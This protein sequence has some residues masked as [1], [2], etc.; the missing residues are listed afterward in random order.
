MNSTRRFLAILVCTVI[1]VKGNAMTY[2]VRKGDTLGEVLYRK[3]P[4]RIYGSGNNLEKTKRLN[5]KLK[6]I[7]KLTPGFVLKLPK[8][9]GKYTQLE[10]SNQSK[11]NEV[12]NSQDAIAESLNMQ[13]GTKSDEALLHQSFIFGFKF[14]SESLKAVE[15]LSSASEIANSDIG[16]GLFLRW[17]HKWNE[18]IHFFLESSLMKHSF[19][20]AS[21]KTLVDDSLLKMDVVSGLQWNYRR[22]HIFEASLGLVENLI[23]NSES[24]TVLDIDKIVTPSL[25]V[26]G[27]HTLIRFERAYSLYAFWA[28][29]GF[30]PTKQSDYETEWGSF[31]EVGAGSTYSKKGRRFTISVSYGQDSLP[32][33]SLTETNKSIEIDASM[34]VEF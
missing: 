1:S 4:G 33:D 30:F 8:G 5:P 20:V 16:Y 23:L 28:A 11:K 10:L 26:S 27:S 7:H 17:N 13:Q 6:S 22:N 31:W 29:G 9:Q 12:G 14:S 24:S 15:S 21:N 2:V 25:K 3:V 34:G 18:K 32:T 19:N